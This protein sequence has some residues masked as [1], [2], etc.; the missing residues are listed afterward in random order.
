MS[1][2]DI[3]ARVAETVARL[4]LPGWQR[5]NLGR[6]VE[7]QTTGQVADLLEALAALIAGTEAPAKK[8]EK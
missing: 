4:R 8:G 7:D 6:V 3:T 2:Q 1:E 5:S